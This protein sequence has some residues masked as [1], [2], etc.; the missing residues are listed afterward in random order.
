MTPDSKAVVARLREKARKTHGGTSHT[1][2]LLT[3]AASLIEELDAALEGATIAAD[4]TP[5]SEHELSLA[6]NELHC[7]DDIP[8]DGG[9]VAGISALRATRD[10]ERARA[11]TAEAYGKTQHNTAKLLASEEKEQ[12]ARAERMAE[13]L[14]EVEEWWLSEGMK[15]FN[16]APYAMFAVRAALTE[17][18]S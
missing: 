9:I 18:P 10:A 2:A 1:S 12:R 4:L 7:C 6:W 3:E 8:L 16:G 5:G 14:R 11:E 13:A 17:K 15:H